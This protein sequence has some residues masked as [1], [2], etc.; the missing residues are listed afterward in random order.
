MT[1]KFDYLDSLNETIAS[2]SLPLAATGQSVHEKLPEEVG[3]CVRHAVI[4]LWL[5]KTVFNDV[6][7]VQWSKLRRAMFV[8]LANAVFALVQQEADKAAAEAKEREKKLQ[9]V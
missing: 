7:I 6:E 9:K 4:F 3:K 2:A 5:A 8:F 1:K